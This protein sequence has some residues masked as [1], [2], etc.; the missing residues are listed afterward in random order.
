MSKPTRVLPDFIRQAPALPKP[1]GTSRPAVKKAPKKLKKFPFNGIFIIQNYSQR[2]SAIYN[3]PTRYGKFHA[4]LDYGPGFLFLQTDMDDV[5]SEL[6]NHTVYS[7]TR[8]EFDDGEW[9][10]T[11]ICRKIELLPPDQ[12]EDKFDMNS[13]AVKDLEDAYILSLYQSTK[14]PPPQPSQQDDEPT[15]VPVHVDFG[16]GTSLSQIREQSPTQES[17]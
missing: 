7:C 17:P 12:G 5:L 8:Q 10:P 11:P 14:T 16:P 15:Q 1:A 3:F 4:D 13:K 2:Y 6:F 9:N